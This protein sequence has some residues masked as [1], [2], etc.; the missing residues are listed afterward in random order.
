M[1]HRCRW[2]L[3]LSAVAAVALIAAPSAAA[4][5]P[6]YYI[7]TMQSGKTFHPISGSNH[8]LLSSA[9]YVSLTTL[10]RSA[11]GAAHLPFRL[12]AYGRTYASVQVS[13]NGDMTFGSM[14]IER[15]Q[16]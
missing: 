8:N 16:Q 2:A 14:G 3:T 7:I 5:I 1:K 4:S 11:S 13:S 15:V 9:A 12:P 6:G 10:S